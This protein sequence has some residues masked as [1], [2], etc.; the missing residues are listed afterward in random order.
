M[1]YLSKMTTI[2]KYYH[3]MQFAIILYIIYIAFIKTYI[4]TI[5]KLL[6]GYTF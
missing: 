2:V 3:N 4:F 5:I 6:E 1:L